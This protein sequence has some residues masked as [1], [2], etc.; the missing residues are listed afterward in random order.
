MNGID[1]GERRPT[2]ITVYRRGNEYLCDVCGHF[3]GGYHGALAGRTLD[4]VVAYV[5]REYTRYIS[6]NPLGGSLVVPP[7]VRER[8][9]QAGVISGGF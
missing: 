2:T 7:E 9:Q 3:S 4:E 6:N 5:A 8:L 1:F